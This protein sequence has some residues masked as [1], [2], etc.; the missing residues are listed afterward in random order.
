MVVNF[1]LEMVKHVL[2]WVVSLLVSLYANPP[3]NGTE[4][5]RTTHTH[6][7]YRGVS[8]SLYGL[9]RSASEAEEEFSQAESWC[10]D[11]LTRRPFR[12]TP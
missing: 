5:Q 6:F 7:F 3:K 1:G 2:T 10:G 8:R 9:N 11:G 12:K 4:P